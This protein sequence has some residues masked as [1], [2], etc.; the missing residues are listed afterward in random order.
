MVSSCSDLISVYRT[1]S[2]ME[3][4]LLYYCI[5]LVILCNSL[6]IFGGVCYMPGSASRGSLTI[7]IKDVSGRCDAAVYR[8][9]VVWFEKRGRK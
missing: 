7:A 1:V 2:R 9:I 4:A 8:V 6:G 3:S 5:S